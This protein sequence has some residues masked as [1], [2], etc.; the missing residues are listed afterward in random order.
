MLMS[1]EILNK[2]PVY[3]TPNWLIIYL[4]NLIYCLWIE[5][6]EVPVQPSCYN[7]LYTFFN[8]LNACGTNNYSVLQ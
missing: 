5:I 7:T 3:N 1:F 6:F 8:V 2:H 4:K